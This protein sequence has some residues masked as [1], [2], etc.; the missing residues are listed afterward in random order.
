MRE[1]DD[2]MTVK[3]LLIETFRTTNRTE[4]KV[5]ELERRLA[6]V[7]TEVQDVKNKVEDHAKELHHHLSNGKDFK[8]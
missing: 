8:S 3:D 2:G 1:D 7:E 6:D 4:A 5:E